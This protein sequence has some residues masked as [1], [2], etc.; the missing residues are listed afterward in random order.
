METGVYWKF[1]LL[2]EVQKRT[3][4]RGRQLTIDFLKFAGGHGFGHDCVRDGRHE[5][6][7]TG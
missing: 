1:D 6:E 3:I 7:E 5:G 4:G 2:E